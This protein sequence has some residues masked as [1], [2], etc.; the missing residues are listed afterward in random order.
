MAIRTFVFAALCSRQ[1]TKLQN[2]KPDQK[3]EQMK[4][5]QVLHRVEVF[6]LMLKCATADSIFT[7]VFFYVFFNFVKN[8]QT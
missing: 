6:F 5:P 8:L 7:A 3:A 1:T 4:E 2:R